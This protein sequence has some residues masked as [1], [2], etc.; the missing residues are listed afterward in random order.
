METFHNVIKENI[1]LAMLKALDAIDLGHGQ[2]A[3]QVYSSLVIPPDTKLGD[4]AYACF[5]L[6]KTLKKSPAQ[7][8]TLISDYLQKEPIAFVQVVQAAGPYLNF[9]LDEIQVAQEILPLIDAGTFFQKTLLEKTPKTMF[10]YSQPNTHKELHVGH[11]RNLCLGNALVRLHRYCNFDVVSSTFPGDMGTHVAKCL[12]YLKNHNQ[13]PVPESRKGAWLGEM[14][15]KASIKLEDEK[16]GEFYEQN[17]SELTAILKELEAQ[18]GEYYQLW[19][20]T[21]SWSID[22]MKDIYKWADVDFDEWYFES[23]V[24]EESIKLVKKYQDIGLFIKDQGAVGLD[25]SEEKLG[26]MLLLKSDGTGLYATKDLE[27]ARRKFKEKNIEKSIYI[28]DKRQA[29]HFKQVFRALELMGFE[30]AKD[31]FHLQYD[32][33]ELP[34]GAMSSRKGNIVA[35]QELIQKMV[36]KIKIDH[37]GKY[38]DQ[39]D[40]NEVNLVADQVA[41]GAIKYG[42]IRMDNN[43]KIVFQMDEWLKLDGESGPYIQYVGARIQSILNRF[44]DE[45]VSQVSFENLKHASERNLIV[46]LSLFNDVV[47]QSCLN[48]K[49]STLCSYLF[50]LSKLFNSF[51]AECSIKNAENKEIRLARLALSGGVRKVIQQG[52]S[53]LGIPSPMKM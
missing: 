13:Q 26:F 46:K 2:S 16:D 23:E 9:L 33:V 47:V 14:Y 21:R 41:Q 36:E 24:D 30:Q 4:L 20:E 40:D 17:K 8:A 34:D 15:S 7:I 48:Y 27:L 29:L 52:L 35:L 19:Q 45:D 50:E 43:K 42:M 11:M 3:R 37:L 44:K 5:P 49:T 51:Y 18:K 25:L 10:E 38:G 32:F 39:W 6:A 28:V 31:C 22:L 53:I 12:W 1:Q